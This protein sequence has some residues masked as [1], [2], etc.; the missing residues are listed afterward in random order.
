MKVDF[1][2]RIHKPHISTCLA[3]IS[4]ITVSNITILNKNFKHQK[5]YVVET[6]CKKFGFRA[7]VKGKLHHAGGSV[8]YPCISFN[9]NFIDIEIKGFPRYPSYCQDQISARNCLRGYGCINSFNKGFPKFQEYRKIEF[10]NV[11]TTK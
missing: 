7:K 3:D 5:P 9:R 2:I 11:V 8:R 6:N 4:D 1:T 10:L